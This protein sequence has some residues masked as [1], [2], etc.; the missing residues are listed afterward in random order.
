[1][2]RTVLVVDDDAAFRGLAVRLLEDWGHQVVGEA[3]S[4]AE[5]L[6]QAAELRPEAALVD[7]ALPDGTGFDLTAS[8]VSL[9]WPVRVVLISSDADPAFTGAA[10][11]AGAE[12]FVPKD[13]LTDA[14]ARRLLAGR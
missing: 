9:P 10:H 4:V 5:A 14:A 7:I 6:A 8:L 2:T 13:Q 1:M 12:G 11:R 3:G